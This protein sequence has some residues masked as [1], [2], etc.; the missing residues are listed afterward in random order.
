MTDEELR[1]L[2]AETSRVAAENSRAI[3]E[4]SERRWGGLRAAVG[5][6]AATMAGKPRGD[7]RLPPGTDCAILALSQ[8][9]NIPRV[10]AFDR[11]LRRRLGCRVAAEFRADLAQ[12]RFRSGSTSPRMLAPDGGE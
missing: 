10:F 4:D 7:P 9:E 6:V 2:V 5:G 12:R 1:D 11:A 8:R 3:R